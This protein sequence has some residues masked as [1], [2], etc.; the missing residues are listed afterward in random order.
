MGFPCNQVLNHVNAIEACAIRQGAAQC[1]SLHLL[2]GTLRVITWGW[3][4][5]N[6]TAGHV[7]STDR[8]LT[9]AAGT[10]LL[11]RLATCTRNFGAVLGLV[12]TLAGSSKLCNDNLVQQRDVGL[13]VEDLCRQFDVKCLSHLLMLPSRRCVRERRGRGHLERHP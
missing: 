5:D 9:G 4:V 7:W 1:S 13:Y 2:R 3:T 12:G 10:L 6:A 11:E 8:T